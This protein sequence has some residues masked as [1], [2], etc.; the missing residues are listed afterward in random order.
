MTTTTTV[1]SLNGKYCSG[2]TL[3]QVKEN[4]EGKKQRTL[5]RAILKFNKV[6][7]DGDGTLSID[8]IRAYDLKKKKQKTAV[9]VGIGVVLTTALG[10]ALYA[11]SKKNS[12][13]SALQSHL[14]EANK[15][16]D[17]P[18]GK[19]IRKETSERAEVKQ[20]L[21][22]IQTRID[23]HCYGVHYEQLDKGRDIRRLE[24]LAIEANQALD[25]RFASVK[26]LAKEIL[27]SPN[28]GI[29][30]INKA[31]FQDHIFL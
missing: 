30:K 4:N 20:V 14:A 5:D 19:V 26:S 15:K 31:I 7:N 27:D 13:I 25:T 9:A 10:V 18:L 28:P 8:E 16:L 1:T 29:E 11:I 22:T 24:A 17:T 12:H 21:E 6:D 3:A 23:D 2:L